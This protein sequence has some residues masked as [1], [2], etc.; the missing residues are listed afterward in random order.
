MKKTKITI[1]GPVYVGDCAQ[2]YDN[3]AGIVFEDVRLGQ[4]N[5]SVKRVNDKAWGP[6][7]AKL[8]V[9]H[10]SAE[11]RRPTEYAGLC[12]IDTGQCGVFDLEYYKKN[13]P[14]D[15]F[16]NPESWYRQMCDIAGTDGSKRLWGTK[17]DKCVNGESGLGDGEYPCSVARDER[18]RIVAIE[19]KYI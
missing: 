4:W 10:E 16:D 14:D 1:D 18:G 15:D 3:G 17:D 5:V 6:R 11:R 2:E 12:W 8:T 13:F 9:R 19:I 7:I